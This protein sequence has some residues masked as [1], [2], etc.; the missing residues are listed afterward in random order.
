MVG[1][2]VV[3]A[4]ANIEQVSSRPVVWKDRCAWAEWQ[5]R[6]AAL[7][8]VKLAALGWGVGFAA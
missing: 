8:G 2:E 4:H 7:G 5:S 3:W 6:V 1:E